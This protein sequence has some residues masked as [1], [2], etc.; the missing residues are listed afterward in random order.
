MFFAT[1]HRGL[2]NGAAALLVSVAALLLAGPGF[3]ADD[4]P[5]EIPYETPGLIPNLNVEAIKTERREAVVIMDHALNPRSV[6]LEE[7]EIVAWISYSGVPS[8]VVFE[9]E[10][11]RSMICHSLVNFSIQ[12]EEIRSAEIHAGEF[13]SFCELKPGRYRYSVLR[14]ASGKMAIS[15][16]AKRMGMSYRRAWL[17][18][19]TMNGCFRGP[20][21]ASTRGGTGGGGARLT[22]LG[23][24]I[25]ARYRKMESKAADCLA[26]DL[27]AFVKLMR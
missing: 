24:G 9:R 13:A 8:V 23:E 4:R 25:L 27:S 15:A 17:L 26:D 22:P 6:K 1:T 14:A 20:L 2:R 10:V 16:A 19:D 7:G 11:A 21:V 12:D 18:A 3:G 5:T